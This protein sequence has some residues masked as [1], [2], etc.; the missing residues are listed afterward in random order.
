MLEITRKVLTLESQEVMEL[1]RIITDED[2]EDAYLFLKKCIYRKLHS[3]QENKLKSHLDGE[4]DPQGSFSA[5]Q[6]VD[7]QE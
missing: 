6:E 5:R 7:R 3:S 4:K 1:E 2:K